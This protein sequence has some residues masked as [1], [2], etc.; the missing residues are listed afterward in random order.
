[1][2]TL[3]L[4]ILSVAFS[5]TSPAATIQLISGNLTASILFSPD[6]SVVSDGD[7]RSTGSFLVSNPAPVGIVQTS[8]GGAASPNH[9]IIAADFGLSE[10]GTLT[11]FPTLA[12]FNPSKTEMTVP[13]VGTP[14][15]AITKPELAAFLG[16]TSAKFSLLGVTPIGGGNIATYDFTSFD[17]GTGS[18]IPEPAA[19]GLVALGLGGLCVLRVRRR[20]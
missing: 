13:V 1:M 19:A 17:P 14:G 2:R 9:V 16:V 8:D 11:F 5:L 20:I 18:P 4:A 15:G 7:F 6:F 3:A 12:T 10:F